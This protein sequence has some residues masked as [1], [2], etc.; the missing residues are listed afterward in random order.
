M[1]AIAITLFSR[2]TVLIQEIHNGS[3]LAS[4][5]GLRRQ[6]LAGKPAVFDFE[7]DGQKCAD[8][9]FRSQW[10]QDFHAGA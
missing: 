2:H 6:Q 10:F 7:S 9:Q 5:D 4:P 3:T 8:F 1:I